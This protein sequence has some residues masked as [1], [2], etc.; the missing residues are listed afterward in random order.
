[1]IR[2]KSRGI[3]CEDRKLDRSMLTIP[4]SILFCDL[5]SWLISSVS[6]QRGNKTEDNRESIRDDDDAAAVFSQLH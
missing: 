4:S 2:E 1:M 5:T 6:C 3:E